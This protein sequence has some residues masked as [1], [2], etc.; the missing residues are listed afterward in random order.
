MNATSVRPEMSIPALL[1]QRP[2]AATLIA[3]IRNGDLNLRVKAV[4]D[5]VLVGSSLIVP[6]GRVMAES[7]PP[8]ARAALEALRRVTHHCAR[9]GAA[10]ERRTAAT[11]LLKLTAPSFPRAV[12]SEAVYLLGCI[13]SPQQVQALANLVR[14]S[15]VGEDARMA[16][17]RIPGS[18]AA[19]ARS[20]SR[21]P[22]SN[23]GG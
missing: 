15:A 13:G 21:G 17:G 16:L 4:Q 18:A 7:D 12:R 3:D 20:R 5:S 1:A 23:A 11:E 14:D 9:P 22:A 6:L 2:T 19:R 8:A 10:D